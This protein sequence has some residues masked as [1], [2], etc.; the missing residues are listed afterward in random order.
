MNKTL[1]HTKAAFLFRLVFLVFLI[2]IA[3][4]GSAQEYKIVRDMHLWS[5]VKLEK[6]FGKDWSVFV[7]E[8]LRLKHDISEINNHLSETGLRYRINK[9]F[10][11]EGQYRITRNKKKA[12]NY[13]TLTR[14][15]FDFRYK[16]K[17]DFISLHYRIR[18]QK[19]VEGWN[20]ID[21]ELPY[22]KYLRN[23]ITLRY[24]QFGRIIPYISGEVFQLF[25]PNRI[26]KYDNVR[27]LGGLK[28][29][30]YKAGEINLAY[31]FNREL[32]SI[33]PAMIYLLKLNYSYSF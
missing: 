20:L 18:Y 32:N 29:R 27:V 11:L 5:G 26:A 13:E 16:G 14:Y 2:N 17:L 25:E 12:G 10:A 19:E 33:Q 21:P 9:N 8:E 7:A 23:R 15:A 24:N 3:L 1:N 6:S 22:E 28:Y 31:G 30:H 4:I